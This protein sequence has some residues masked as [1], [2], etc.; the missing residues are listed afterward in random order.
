M[1][2]WHECAERMWATGATL[3]QI[4]EAT[5]TA[6][7]TIRRHLLTLERGDKD[8]A[9]IGWCPVCGQPLHQD[10]SRA[11]QRFCCNAHRRTWWATHPEHR[12]RHAT[13]TFT[14]TGCGVRFSTYGQ[15]GRRYCSQACYHTTRRARLAC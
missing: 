2:A 4:A 12:T 5:D 15:P 8:P 10:T 14:C 9:T 3:R 6:V 13:Y 1:T 7:S 11:G